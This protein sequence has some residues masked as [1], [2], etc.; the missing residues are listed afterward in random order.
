MHKA[1][2][3]LLFTASGLAAQSA[4][5]VVPYEQFQL[6]NGLN[7]ILHVDRTTPTVSVNTWFHVGSGYEEPGRT[8]FAHL[9]EHLMFEGYR[10][11]GFDNQT[12]VA[13]VGPVADGQHRGLSGFF[14]GQV[15][16]GQVTGRRRDNAFFPGFFACRDRGW[17]GGYPL[18]LQQLFLCGGGHVAYLLARHARKV[19]ATDLS[20]EMLAAVAETARSRGLHNI[21]TAE[22]SADRLPFADGA[23]R[24]GVVLGFMHR[25]PAEIRLAALDEVLGF[26][27]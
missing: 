22:A 23:F 24:C 2:L 20:P 1:L 7:V 4:R 21:E 13:V 26:L 12:G 27:L 10:R 18:D 19:T 25:V 14:G 15:C 16:R 17:R 6:P 3:V 9:F 5:I 11:R 8:G